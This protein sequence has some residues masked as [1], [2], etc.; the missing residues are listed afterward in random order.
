M[1]AN[2]RRRRKNFN[3]AK[4]IYVQISPASP[5]Y[6]RLIEL[7]QKFDISYHRV[8]LD[9]IDWYLNTQAR[10]RQN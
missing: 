8:A 7:S 4:S 1:Q 9:A 2:K 5:R 6:H 10:T 3:P